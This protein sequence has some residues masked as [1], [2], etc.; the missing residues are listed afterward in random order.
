MRRTH[1][2][3]SEAWMPY[4]TG[5]R[6]L[7]LASDTS[8]RDRDGPNAPRSQAL[9]L[10]RSPQRTGVFGGIWGGVT[11]R[12]GPHRPLAWLDLVADATGSG[13]TLLTNQVICLTFSHTAHQNRWDGPGS[14]QRP[15]FSFSFPGMRTARLDLPAGCCLKEPPIRLG[16]T[17]ALL[18]SVTFPVAG[19]SRRGVAIG[20]RRIRTGTVPAIETGA[21]YPREVSVKDCYA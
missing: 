19:A 17:H 14:R 5:V 2:P 16:P 11:H 8:F 1:A 12:L 13:G 21:Q 9:P 15:G 18:V 6:G 7:A 10:A 20:L 3:L 4:A